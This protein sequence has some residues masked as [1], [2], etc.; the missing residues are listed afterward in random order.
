MERHLVFMDRKLNIFKTSKKISHFYSI[1]TE[2]PISFLRYRKEF[3][4]YIR[5]LK[6]GHRYLYTNILSS[7]IHNSQKVETI[8]SPSRNGSQNKCDIHTQWNITEP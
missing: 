1:F 2:I 3:S 5:E 7:I 4:L 6:A 8:E